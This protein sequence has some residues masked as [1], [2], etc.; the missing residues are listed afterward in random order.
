MN[1]SSPFTVHLEDEYVPS[2][3]DVAASFSV[4]SGSVGHSISQV[5]LMSIAYLTRY[6]VEV[7][8]RH[9][10][11]HGVNPLNENTGTHYSTYASNFTTS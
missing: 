9:D 10:H 8:S 2:Y 7:N 3:S 11:Q 5:H 4:R 6:Y 1:Q